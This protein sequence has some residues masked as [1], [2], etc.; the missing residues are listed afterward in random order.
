VTQAPI[1]LKGSTG[2]VKEFFAYAINNILFQRGVYPPTSFKPT[3]KYGLTMQMTDEAGLRLYM[4]KILKY[5]EH[6]VTNKDIQKLVL[7]IKSFETKEAVERW[8]FNV[9]VTGK[10]GN[11]DTDENMGENMT[12]NGKSEKEIRNDIRAIMV[13]ITSCVSFL[14]LLEEECTFDIL[15]YTNKETETPK[16]WEESDPQY[17]ADAEHVRLRSFDTP[18]HKVDSIVAYKTFQD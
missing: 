6:W 16:L 15:V 17:V 8:A 14:P 18:H 2:I 10:K 1:S 13:Q 12:K 3:K 9:Q 5:V 11:Q 4:A 7:V